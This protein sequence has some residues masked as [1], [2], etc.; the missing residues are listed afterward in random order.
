M[1]DELSDNMASGSAREFGARGGKIL[2]RIWRVVVCPVRIH[3]S[4]A[5][6]KG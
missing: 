4:G 2:K 1:C 5:S 3:M 6:G